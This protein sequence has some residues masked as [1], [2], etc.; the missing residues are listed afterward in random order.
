MIKGKLYLKAMI[1]YSSI[2]LY[3]GGFT[4]QSQFI[5]FGVYCMLYPT[6]FLFNVNPVWF[7]ISMIAST[8]GLISSQFNDLVGWI[9]AN[10]N[11]ADA[12]IAERLCLWWFEDITM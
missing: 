7:R 10:M 9:T 11:K 6:Y 3:F 8:I 4:Y 12:Q 2:L 1:R 5:T